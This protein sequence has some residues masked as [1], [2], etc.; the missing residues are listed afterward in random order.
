M[1]TLY[2][3]VGWSKTGTSAIQMQL[4]T[5]MYNLLSKNILYPQSL[6]WPDHSHHPFALSFQSNGN[7]VSNLSPEQAIQKLE[8]EMSK[9][10]ADDVLISSE[11]S[12]F[13]F[14]N[15][16]FKLF[17]E[18]NFDNVKVIFTI[19]RQSEVLLSLYNQLIKDPQVRF[20]GS[21]FSLGMRN[22]SWLNYFMNVKR[23]AD[24][25]GDENIIIIP[26]SKNVVSDF[27][28]L[29]GLELVGVE[30]SINPSLPTRCLP[31]I[32]NFT[33]NATDD[34]SYIRIRD[35]IVQKSLDIPESENWFT[36]FTVAEQSAF[37][38]Y[39]EM[40]NNHLRN[41]F[42][43]LGS[44]FTEAREIKDIKSLPPGFK[45]EDLPK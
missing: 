8:V 35:A 12:P 21:L 29:F 37:N 20:K 43:S 26:Y 23:W 32:Q 34:A 28:S 40:S 38:D 1:R 13:Y 2:L 9:S 15:N 5:Q 16:E 4:Q 7:Y 30:K 25:V 19:R 44:F 10:I 24:V 31:V 42:F 36:L 6:Q 27:I 14:K 22:I 3:H 39:F 41:S 45:F 18:R 33:K 11:L 17:V